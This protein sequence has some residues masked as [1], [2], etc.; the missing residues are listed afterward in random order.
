MLR[1]FDNTR[2]YFPAAN[3]APGRRS[4]LLRRKTTLER[5]ELLPQQSAERSTILPPNDQ[6]AALPVDRASESTCRTRRPG[7]ALLKWHFLQMIG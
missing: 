1:A 4:F 5:K 2:S 7:T 3:P 6:S